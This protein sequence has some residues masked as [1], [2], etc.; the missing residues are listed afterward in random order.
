[1]IPEM[2]YNDADDCIIRVFPDFKVNSRPS[3]RL[4]LIDKCKFISKSFQEIC[5]HE[6]LNRTQEFYTTLNESLIKILTQQLIT[7]KEFSFHF[8]DLITKK[9]YLYCD[10]PTD[11]GIF[12]I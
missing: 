11:Y 5:F 10:K 8:V 12:K 1:M 7:S 2:L 4:F 9:I 3:N 6:D